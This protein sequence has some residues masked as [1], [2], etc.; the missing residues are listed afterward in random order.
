MTSLKMLF[1]NVFMALVLVLAVAAQAPA[2]TLR[3]KVDN[4]I[5]FFDHSGSMVQDNEMFKAHKLVL[6]KSLALRMNAAIPD[7]G[8]QSGV[9]TY[10]PFAVQ[11]TPTAYTRTAVSSAVN[12]IDTNYE[13]YGRITPMGPGLKSIDATLATLKGRTA[14]IIFTDGNSNYGSDPVDEAKAL[15]AKYPNLCIHIV[16]YADKAHGKEVVSAIRALKDCTVA[17]DPIALQGDSALKQFVRDVF[18]DVVPEEAPA[19]ARTMAP[20]KPECE[21]ITLGNMNFAFDK[22]EIT[23]GME[24]ALELALSVMTKSSCAR[25]VVEGHTCNIG[26]DE[27]NQGLS[28]RRANSVAKWLIEK[29]YTGKLEISGKGE[30]APKYDNSNA[31]GRSLN[32]RVEIRNN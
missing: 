22:Y 24:P 27:Y 14:L 28:L 13:I 3:P 8:Y 12:G 9:N 32:R 10:A 19:P 2:E 5:L 20:E 23:A 30:S 31:E 6:A 7:L 21:T 18:Y 11:L 26:T 1:S 25:F 4:F 16:S 17:G 29:G 15:Y